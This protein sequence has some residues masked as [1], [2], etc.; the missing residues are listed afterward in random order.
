VS[1]W[2]LLAASSAA[3]WEDTYEVITGGVQATIAATSDVTTVINYTEGDALRAA[4][5]GVVELLRLVRELATRHD[6][7]LIDIHEVDS[8][9][10]VAVSTI[11]IAR[12]VVGSG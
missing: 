2:M 5:A 7:V 12:H 1:S 4:T 3:N 8:L 10:T 6:I 11:V 9:G